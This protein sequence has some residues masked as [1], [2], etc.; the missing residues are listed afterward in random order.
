MPFNVYNQTPYFDTELFSVDN[1]QL[2]LVSQRLR[3]IIDRHQIISFYG[4]DFKL[5]F[6]LTGKSL[7]GNN[8][9]NST[10]ENQEEASNTLRT[11]YVFHP[12]DPLVI[13][14]TY[15]QSFQITA[16][17]LQYYFEDDE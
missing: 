3:R 11:S 17:Y 9:N 16:H 10:S 13:I 12:S 6:K 2:L 5:K 4:K 1:P 8:N 7:P 14:I 15:N